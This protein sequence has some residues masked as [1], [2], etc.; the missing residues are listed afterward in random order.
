MPNGLNTEKRRMKTARLNCLT[1]FS[2][3]YSLQVI[4]F[5]LNDLGYVTGEFLLLPAE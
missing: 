2:Y 5:M 3:D 4:T 1:V